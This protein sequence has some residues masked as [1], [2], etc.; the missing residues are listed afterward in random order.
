MITVKKILNDQFPEKMG[1]WSDEDFA[2]VEVV[3]LTDQNII[4]IDNLDLFDNITELDLQHNKITKI[5][6]LGHLMKLHHLDLSGN[7]IDAGG[8]SVERL[9]PNLKTINLS[10][11]PCVS[12]A[13]AMKKFEKNYPNV[14]VSC[15][16]TDD[17]IHHTDT[18]GP[19][20]AT[21][22]SSDGEAY[23]DSESV[24]RAVVDRKCRL[25]ALAPVD[26]SSTLQ[27]LEKVGESVT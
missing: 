25:Q 16:A 4:E 1:V 10:G 27:N 6:N 17:C 24:L 9:P 2:K 7:A 23:L 22:S 21:V 13:E 19:N 26:I 12:C 5:E 8:L 3:S 20:P 11:N 18:Q 14:R 15:D